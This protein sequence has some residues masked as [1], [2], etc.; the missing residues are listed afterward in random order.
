[1]KHREDRR[2]PEVQQLG[3]EGFEEEGEEWEVSVCPVDFG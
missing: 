2:R 1:M 3:G